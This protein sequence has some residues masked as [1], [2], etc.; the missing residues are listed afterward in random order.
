VW[1][2]SADSEARPNDPTL[3]LIHRTARPITAA[4]LVQAAGKDAPAPE[5]RPYI[6][7]Y[8]ISP[9]GHVFKFV[10]EDRKCQHASGTWGGKSANMQ[11]IGIELVSDGNYPDVQMK[12]L[13]KL[14]LSFCD[15]YSIE[16]VIGH[17]D[18]EFKKR[19]FDP[20]PK[21][22]WP[23][24]ERLLR[25][26]VCYMIP[27]SPANMTAMAFRGKQIYGGFFETFSG[28][29][30]KLHDSDTAHKYGGKVTNLRSSL[31]YELTADLKDIGYACKD[32]SI[33]GIST[34]LAVKAFQHHFF[35]GTRFRGYTPG[36]VDLATAEMIKSVSTRWTL[37]TP[38]SLALHT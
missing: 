20:G 27:G 1:L 2:R 22:D 11:S 15:M 26:R 12:A 33:F 6:T 19:D 21:F 28:G 10:T 4:L 9:E 14:L 3:V 5:H 35:S 30:L 17:N 34:Q 18:V 32:G 25:G 31:I 36:E 37:S 29:R 8:G 38:T 16:A 23:R 7:H 24:I 13:E